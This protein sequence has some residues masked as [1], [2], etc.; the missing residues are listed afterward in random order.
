MGFKVISRYPLPLPFVKD[1]LVASETLLL[2]P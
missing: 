1:L 2:H